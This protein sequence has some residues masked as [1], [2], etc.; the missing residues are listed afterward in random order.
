M[1]RLAPHRTKRF[2]IY[3][4]VYPLLPVVCCFCRRVAVS[5]WGSLSANAP[6]DRSRS[7]V[8]PRL[9]RV[10]VRRQLC[11]SNPREFCCRRLVC[12][13]ALRTINF[14]PWCVDL[15][16]PPHVSDTHAARCNTMSVMRATRCKEQRDKVERKREAGVKR[17]DSRIDKRNNRPFFQ[18]RYSRMYWTD[19]QR[20]S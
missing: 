3:R 13:T 10:S 5:R 19:N 14:S 20:Q 1:T 4:R 7:L 18:V 11:L 8:I 16:L 12:S 9:F 17:V 6:V 15:A 2:R